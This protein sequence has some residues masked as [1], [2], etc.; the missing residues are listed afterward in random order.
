[1]VSKFQWTPF[2][3]ATQRDPQNDWAATQNRVN[4]DVFA[5]A[6]FLCFSSSV[7]IDFQ[8]RARKKKKQFCPSVGYCQILSPS[9][10]RFEFQPFQAFVQFFTPT[11]E[12]C[13]QN[14]SPSL[15]HLLSSTKFK[16]IPKTDNAV[17][18]TPFGISFLRLWSLALRCL[19]F[20]VP[21]AKL[22]LL[23]SLLMALPEFGILLLYCK[24]QCKN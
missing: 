22:L 15:P 13:E 1:M 8:G 9:G 19:L 24:L 21:S 12:G 18:K 20:S 16:P 17:S 4:Y 14:W 5:Q 6:P 10:G 11:W 2:W 3:L 7:R 23:T